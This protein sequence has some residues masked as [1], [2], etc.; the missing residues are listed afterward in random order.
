MSTRKYKLTEHALYIV[1]ERNIDLS[2]LTLTINLPDSAEIQSDGT[3]HYL[4][5][6][7]ENI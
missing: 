2:W 6:I 5:L 3:V 4:K 7:P 1:K